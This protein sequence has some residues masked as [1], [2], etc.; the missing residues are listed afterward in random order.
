MDDDDDDDE[1]P[2]LVAKGVWGVLC[3]VAAV[4]LRFL[5]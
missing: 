4:A 3:V 2:A 5:S 1:F